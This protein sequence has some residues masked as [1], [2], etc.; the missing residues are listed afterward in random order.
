MQDFL[1]T[2]YFWLKAGHI[3]FVVF[4]MAGL[5]MLPRL[6]LAFRS[7]AFG[8]DE[9]Y[10]A[11]VCGAVLGLR[12]ASRL[13]RR[14]VRE[15]QVAVVFVVV[16]ERREW[17]GVGESRVHGIEARGVAQARAAD[18]SVLSWQRALRAARRREPG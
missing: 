1:A 16:D 8:T 3:V 13:R 10:P 6:F 4:W 5:F 17:P 2:I 14:L 7:P 9:Y 18:I 15:R 12:N 11:S